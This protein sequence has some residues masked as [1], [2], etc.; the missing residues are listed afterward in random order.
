MK[1]KFIIVLVLV[2]FSC[3]IQKRALKNKEQRQVSEL[4]ETSIKRKGDT[5]TYTVPKIVLK[6]TTIY[7]V[8]RQGTTLKTV[9]DNTGKISDVD[10]YTSMIDEV[11]KINKQLVEAIKN[12]DQEKT[13]TFDSTIV[14]YIML[15]IGIIVLTL[16][17]FG[18][19][20]LNQ[21]TSAITKVLER[22]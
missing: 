3:D 13:E 17:F 21:N 4:T 6:D 10:C 14:L 15:G 8:N 18:F 12:K 16:A 11:T 9:Y 19:K 5:V 20:L 1:I 7:T 22:L 2:F